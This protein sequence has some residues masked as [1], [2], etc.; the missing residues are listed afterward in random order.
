MRGGDLHW[1]WK[2]Y[3]LYQDIDF[4]YGIPSFESGDGF[5][6]AQCEFYLIQKTPSEISSFPLL[7]SCPQ[8]RRDTTQPLLSH[9]ATRFPLSRRAARRPRERRHDTLEDGAVLGTGILLRVLCRWA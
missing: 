6:N 4:V 7:H 1:V 3:S 9:F 8:Y 2:P 5:T